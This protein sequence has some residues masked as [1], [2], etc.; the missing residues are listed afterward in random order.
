MFAGGLKQLKN[1]TR[2]ELDEKLKKG[3]WFSDN[4]TPFPPDSL[5]ARQEFTSI[6]PEKGTYSYL[7]G[8]I[9]KFGCVDSMSKVDGIHP[10]ASILFSAGLCASTW[11]GRKSACNSYARFCSAVNIDC[12][13]PIS[14]FNLTHYIAY[15]FQ[16]DKVSKD[17]C[18]NYI[19]ALKAS[20]SS[21]GYDVSIFD[22]IRVRQTISGYQN[23]R[24]VV[25]GK[26]HNDRR[27]INMSI[28]K[29]LGN[30]LCNSNLTELELANYWT[31]SLFGFWA[32]L[33]SG[34]ILPAGY[35]SEKVCLGL[36]WKQINY[37]STNHI[38]V[39]LLFP[40]VR[41][42][43]GS[44]IVDLIKVVDSRYCPIT[45]LNRL[46]QL[47]NEIR[48]TSLDDHIFK[49]YLGRPILINQYNKILKKTLSVKYPGNT[50]TLYSYRGGI[51]HHV[52]QHPELFNIED[53]ESLGRWNS[54][55]YKRYNR[56]N[57]QQRL[58][59][60]S[61]ISSMILDKKVLFSFIR[62]RSSILNNHS[63]LVKFFK[64]LLYHLTG[65]E[66]ERVQA[67]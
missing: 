59:V 42:K 53:L 62:S 61:R 44:E 45:W 3:A 23:Y 7:D 8:R 18:Q 67:S 37:L 1:H 55:T 30:M 34:E 41:A 64:I 32:S 29:T 58:G 27:I 63:K 16:T 13:F 46:Y 47:N 65:L 36:H 21:L 22:D 10:T 50:F 52:A 5:L 48:T 40:K 6:S 49:D 51:L 28:L 24:E 33:R 15:L 25:V 12:E 38:S 4:T 66:G 2:T 31:I 39:E 26:K 14:L 56:S 60:L 57:G 35:T 9:G 19:S 20:Q 17:T 54:T 43:E 11:K